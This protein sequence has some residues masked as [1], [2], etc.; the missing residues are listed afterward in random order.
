VVALGFFQGAGQGL[1]LGEEFHH[2]RVNI[3]C[4]QIYGVS[5]EL[6]YRWNQPRLVETAM[7]LQSEGVLCLRPIITQVYPFREAAEAFRMCDYESEKTI[8]VVLDYTS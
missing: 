1:Y 5:P 3:V 2:N 4:S 8:Q 6:T 7:R